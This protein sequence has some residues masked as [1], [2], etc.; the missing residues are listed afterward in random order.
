MR[1]GSALGLHGRSDMDQTSCFNSFAYSSA[2]SPPTLTLF[3]INAM[4]ARDL[5]S[6]GLPASGAERRTADDGDTL[7]ELSNALQ[8]PWSGELPAPRDAVRLALAHRLL[9]GDLQRVAG[10]VEL[11]GD[12]HAEE[13][14]GGKGEKVRHA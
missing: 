11:V 13:E 10:R 8:E 9:D 14:G 4:S 3:R 12:W 2:I 7:R 1:A 5:V 6:S